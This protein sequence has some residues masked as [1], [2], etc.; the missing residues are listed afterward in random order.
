MFRTDFIPMKIKYEK[1][2][3][4]FG[5]RNSYSKTDLDATFMRMKE[6][7]MLNG[8]LKP[9]YNIQMGTEN[10][11]IVGYGA[12]AKPSDTTTLIPHLEGL[13]EQIGRLPENIIAN[14]GYGSEENYAN[15]ERDHLGNYVKTIFMRRRKRKSEKTSIGRK[16]CHTM[17]R[18]IPILAR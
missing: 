17:K 18:Q 8:Q 6:D 2:M 7:A 5:G 12:H 3:E 10:C 16:A 13:K 14:G 15:L 1:A 9:S 4:T 11:Y